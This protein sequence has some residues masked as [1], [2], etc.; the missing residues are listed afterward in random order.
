M[1][2]LRSTIEGCSDDLKILFDGP[3]LPAPPA[4]P[5]PPPPAP[6]TP[7]PVQPASVLSTCETGRFESTVDTSE[8]YTGL[9]LSLP[10]RMNKLSYAS[11]FK[12]NCSKNCSKCETLLEISPP[13]L[14]RTKP[15]C[16]LLLRLQYK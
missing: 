10:L 13:Q 11:E 7:S 12:P 2:A 5:T 14:F 1:R 16:D 4:T 9:S 15:G 8:K 3:K 6:P